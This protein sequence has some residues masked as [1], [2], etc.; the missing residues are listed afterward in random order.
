MK[1]GGKLSGDSGTDPGGGVGGGCFLLPPTRVSNDGTW[2]QH[3]P[4][5]SLSF[6]ATAFHAVD[7]GGGVVLVFGVRG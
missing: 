6:R 7:G 2:K 3:R 4:A 5:L 1:S